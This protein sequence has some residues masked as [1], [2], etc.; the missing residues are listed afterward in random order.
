MRW[1]HLMFSSRAIENFRGV[2]GIHEV[3][4]PLR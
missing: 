1:L 4:K 2:G 3:A